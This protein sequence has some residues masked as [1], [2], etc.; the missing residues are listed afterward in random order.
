[1]WSESENWLSRAIRR[2]GGKSVIIHSMIHHAQRFAQSRGANVLRWLFYASLLA[3]AAFLVYLPPELGAALTV[4]PDSSEYSICLANL[5]EHGRFGFTL[6]GT[7]YPSRYAPWF[8]LLCLAP[9]YLLSGGNVLCMHWAILAFA[10]VV[11]VAS[12]KMGRLC[13]LG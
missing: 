13:G 4:P 5:F 12:W 8:S 2:G 10:L 1:M 7:W 11:L 6:N 3:L 9:A